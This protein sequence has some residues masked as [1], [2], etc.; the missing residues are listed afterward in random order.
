MRINGEWCHQL[1]LLSF[2]ISLQFISLT[3][4]RP[5]SLFH[6]CHR[7][8]QSATPPRLGRDYNF[9]QPHLLPT[10][11]KANMA[12]MTPPDAANLSTQL[13][14]FHRLY[15][16]LQPATSEKYLVP[17]GKILTTSGLRSLF[18]L[19]ISGRR[20]WILFAIHFP[21]PSIYFH[22]LFQVF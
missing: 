14:R 6:L 20:R 19:I 17:P 2:I 15:H 10:A 13:P 4:L 8:Q 7:H 9:V 18:R 1:C 5:T 16:C 11:D 3:I 22:L 12:I 21:I